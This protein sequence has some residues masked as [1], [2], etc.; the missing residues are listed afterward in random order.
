MTIA[1]GDRIPDVQLHTMT[2]DGVRAVSSAEILGKGT[3]VLF[4]VPGAFT[5]TC[6][7]K[8]LPGFVV[9][10]PE[11]RDRGVDRIACVSVNDAFVMDAWGR[12]QGVGNE[13][14]MV[15]DGNGEF[16]RAMGLEMDG[17]GIG[18]GVR[19]QRYAAILQDGIVK[20]LFVES[21]PGLDV[22][23]AESVMAAL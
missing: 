22:S 15:A 1:V 9:R 18:L 17:A 19:S 13:V 21:K 3:V 6:S 23:S 20:G 10:A 7:E 12:E 5:P 4:G 8:H 14:L 2:K 16:T 11:I